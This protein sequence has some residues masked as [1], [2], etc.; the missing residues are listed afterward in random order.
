MPTPAL[1]YLRTSSAANVGGDSDDRQRLAIRRYAK[2]NGI[3]IVG[4]HYDEAVSGSDPIETRPGFSDM[5][6][7]IERKF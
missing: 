5:L 3:E 6:S 2:A 4:E 7:R 1:A